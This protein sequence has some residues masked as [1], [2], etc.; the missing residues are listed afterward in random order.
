MKFSELDA[1]IFDSDG[2]LVDSEIIHI[3]VEQELLSELGLHYER[4]TYLSRFVGLSNADF[5]SQLSSDYALHVGGEFP[6]DFGSMLQER[7]W[8]RI[9]AELQPIDGV[10]DLVEAFHGKVAVGS[11]APLERLTKKLEI[12]NLFSLFS[13]HVY[14]VDSVA[15]GKPAPDLFLHAAE[16]LG[17]QPDKCAVIEDSVHGVI[18]ARAAQMIP[19]GFVGGSHADS[20][21]GERLKASGAEFVVSC[22]SEIHR[23]L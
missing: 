5:Y 4:T 1:L 16:Q 20:G 10:A 19:I 15:K 18:A 2:V 14:S 22:H 13:P 6:S 21:L 23:L 17:A 8:P 3:A 7:L 11:S 9:E 12:A